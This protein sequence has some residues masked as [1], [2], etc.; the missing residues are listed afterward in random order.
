MRCARPCR[1]PGG[2]ML[3]TRRPEARLHRRREHGVHR[4]PRGFDVGRE[5][6]TEPFF[7]RPQQRATDGLVV[8]V[9]DAVTRVAGSQALDDRHQRVERIQPFDAGADHLHQFLAL[10]AQVR[11]K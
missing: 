5:G 2:A 11:R 7:E 10:F 1:D 3:T 4:C 8:S 6:G 9:G